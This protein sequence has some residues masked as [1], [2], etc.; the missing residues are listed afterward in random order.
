M[1]TAGL[2]V[3]RCRNDERT[4]HDVGVHRI[5]LDSLVAELLGAAPVTRRRV[6][7]PS[8]SM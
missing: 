4:L 6:F 7:H 2:D 1:T 3:G 8:R 5:E